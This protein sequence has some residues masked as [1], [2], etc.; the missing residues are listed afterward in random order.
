MGIAKLSL[1]SSGLK[2]PL[3]RTPIVGPGQRSLEVLKKSFGEEIPKIVDIS[4]NPFLSALFA[5]GGVADRIRKKLAALSKKK[6]RIIPAKGTIAS[7]M[8]A[9]EETDFEDAVFLGVDFL[10]EYHQEVATVAGILAHE[11]G[12]LVS[13][14]PYG[15][16][17]NNL[18]WEQ[19]FDLRRDEEA[20]ADVYAGRMLHRMGYRPEALIRFLNQEEFKKYS[21][22]Y[23][24]VPT[25]IAMVG[26]SFKAEERKKR[27]S[28]ILF[29][30]SIYQAPYESSLIA[31]A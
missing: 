7:A 8:A 22:K 5:K 21:A 31:V 20:A 14:F 25:R 29:P 6:G 17:A 18:T 11:W 10:A 9:T 15:I 30:T 2:N 28:R 24:P 26:E 16:D 3:L 4:K 23:H 12:H 13:Q 19:I 27:E 1:A